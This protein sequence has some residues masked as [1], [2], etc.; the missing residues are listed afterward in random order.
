MDASACE[1]MGS[2]EPQHILHVGEAGRPRLPTRAHE[3][4][5]TQGSR[6]E[7]LARCGAVRKLEALA[8]AGEDHRVLAHHVTAAQHR[9]PDAAVA[10]LARVAVPRVD[11]AFFQRPTK[12]PGGSL[13][14][15][16]LLYTSDA[17]DE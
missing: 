8:G 6:R 7:V 4:C 1:P 2:A 14:Q 16:C 10:S 12:A 9:K 15:H 5:R 13:P 3:S 17:A 11:R